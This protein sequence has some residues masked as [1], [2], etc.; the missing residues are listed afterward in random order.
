LIIS[1]I[2]ASGNGVFLLKTAR[3]NGGLMTPATISLIKAFKI[4]MQ[5]N[6]LKLYK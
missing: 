3:Q 5:A 2:L 4:V 1:F 6:D